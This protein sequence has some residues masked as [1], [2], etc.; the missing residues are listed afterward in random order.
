[1]DCV[2]EEERRYTV[3]VQAVIIQWAYSVV[4]NQGHIKVHA[5]FQQE[6]DHLFDD[7]GPKKTLLAEAWKD[8]YED[9]DTNS[10]SDTEPVTQPIQKKQKLDLHSISFVN[11]NFTLLIYGVDS[12]AQ[13][14]LW[15]QALQHFFGDELAS[16]SV[17]IIVK[18]MIY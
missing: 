15:S 14:K 10:D 16:N 4:A 18:K 2:L 11:S 3:Y 1:M 17:V 9:T 8:G 13:C 7:I 6:I 12:L 5:L